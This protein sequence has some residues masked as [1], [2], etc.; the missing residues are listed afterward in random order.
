M[1]ESGNDVLELIH[2]KMTADWFINGKYVTYHL[3]QTAWKGL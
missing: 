1:D 2:K 3:L